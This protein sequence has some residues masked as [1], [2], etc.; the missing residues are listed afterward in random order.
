MTTKQSDSSLE[1][2]ESVLVFWDIS[3]EPL[4]GMLA[5]GRQAVLTEQMGA[6]VTFDGVVRNHDHGCP[7]AGLSYS[8]HPQAG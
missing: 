6:L 4:E 3:S 2:S 1:P 5:G 7:V 8:A